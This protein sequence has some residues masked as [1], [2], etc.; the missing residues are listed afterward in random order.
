MEVVPRSKADDFAYTIEVKR[1][2]EKLVD[3]RCPADFTPVVFERI[4]SAALSAYRTLG[5]RDF[6]RVDFR[7]SAD[8][9]PY[10]LEINPLPGLNPHSGDLPIM[11]RLMGWTYEELVGAVFKAARARYF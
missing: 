6:S 7:V 3:Y 2:W 10:F 4:V 9:V 5:C 11:S 1:D 8:G